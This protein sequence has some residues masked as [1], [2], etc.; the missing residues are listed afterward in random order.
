MSFVARLLGKE[1][2]YLWWPLHQACARH[3]SQG[4]ASMS[5]QLNEITQVPEAHVSWLIAFTPGGH[6]SALFCV[7]TFSQGSPY[8]NSAITSTPRALPPACEPQSFL[9]STSRL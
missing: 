9:V 5:W 8:R 7:L 1:G 3:L 6:L 4:E 2:W